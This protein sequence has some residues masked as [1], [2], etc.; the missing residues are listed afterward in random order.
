MDGWALPQINLTKVLFT[1]SLHDIRSL[2]P[3]K[4]GGHN[5]CPKVQYILH[6]LLCYVGNVSGIVIYYFLLEHIFS[7]ITA[8]TQIYE[9]VMRNPKSRVSTVLKMSHLLI[10]IIGLIIL[11]NLFTYVIL[12]TS[13]F[14]FDLAHN[15]KH[16]INTVVKNNNCYLDCN[17]ILL[18]N[19][20]INKTIR[21]KST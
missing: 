21:N 19:L 8:S 9:R 5:V 13:P 6:Y 10:L 4:G 11:K 18:V 17:M 16:L 20:P 12:T 3:H 14:F 2:L 1:W 15:V 7:V